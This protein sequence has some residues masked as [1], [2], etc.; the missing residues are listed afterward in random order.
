ME[1]LTPQHTKISTLVQLKMP[2]ANLLYIEPIAEV[3]EKPQQ[4]EPRYRLTNQQNL[5]FLSE[6]IKLPIKSD[7]HNE[8][9]PNIVKGLFVDLLSTMSFALS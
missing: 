2:T 5:N 6:S 4:P 9:P 8:G 7:S 3:E 1:H